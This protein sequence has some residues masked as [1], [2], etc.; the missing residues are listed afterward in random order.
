MNTTTLAT[1]TLLS[2]LLFL[3]LN[4]SGCAKP[5]VITY[6]PK[7]FINPNRVVIKKIKEPMPNPKVQATYGLG[8]DPQIEKAYQQFLKSGIA[9]NIESSGF[10]TFAYDS[11]SHPIIACSPLHLCAVQLERGEIINDI[12]VGDSQNWSKPMQ[13]LIGTPED[14]SYQVL[15]KPKYYDIAT[16]LV[17]T[18]NKRTYNIG[19]LS[20]KGTY[21]HVANFY[22]PQETLQYSIEKAHEA[23][24][25]TEQPSKIDITTQLSLDQINFNYQLKGDP[26]AWK[27][28]RV[29]DDGNKTFIQMPPVVERLDLPVLYI[30]KN[31][32]IQLV[33]YRYKQPYYI[34][35]GLFAQAYLISGKGSNQERVEIDNR[36]FG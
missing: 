5:P 15:I 31:R 14:G 36:N 27:P 24:A 10:K 29:F 33:N 34:V 17:I 25:A 4:L 1:I 9:K 30:A 23:N 12:D 3:T 8:N 11:Y 2:I 18:T 28:T 26:V 22:Y 21:T 16:D 32:Q 20:Q 19:L 35:D 7:D 13:A 6:N